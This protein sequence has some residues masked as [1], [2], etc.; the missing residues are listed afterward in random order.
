MNVVYVVGSVVLLVDHAYSNV[1]SPLPPVSLAVIFVFIV[2]FPL[3]GF[4]YEPPFGLSVTV[5]SVLSIFVICLLDV[6]TFPALSVAVAN[7]YPFALTVTLVVGAVVEFDAVCAFANVVP[8][9]AFL[10][11][12]VV[13]SGYVIVAVISLFVHSVVLVF[14]AIAIFSS[15]TI[16]AWL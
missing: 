11:L 7:T 3:V 15:P 1:F 16:K 2:A 13:T 10:V 5:G 9:P 4:A 14:I 6:T 12:F 8:Y